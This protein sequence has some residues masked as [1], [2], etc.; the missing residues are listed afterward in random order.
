MISY[1]EITGK[2]KINFA[3]VSL[4]HA[5]DYSAEDVYMTHKLYEKQQKERKKED[6]FILDLETSLL[7][8]LVSME[9][10]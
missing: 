5:A 4:T 7:E 2:G 6:D 8:V 10:S 9:V 3:D 1:D